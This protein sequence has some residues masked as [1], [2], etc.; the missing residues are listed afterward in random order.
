MTV[1]AATTERAQRAAV[2]AA[3]RAGLGATAVT[4]LP[5]DDQALALDPRLAT[6]ISVGVVSTVDSFDDGPRDGTDGLTSSDLT[7][8]LRVQIISRIRSADP[9]DSYDEHLDRCRVVVGL[10]HGADPEV[11]VQTV[12]GQTTRQG[13]HVLTLYTVQILCRGA[14]ASVS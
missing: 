12:Q 1:R 11:Q 9:A 4:D 10:L 6:V 3:L 7:L 2:I 14:F 8:T 5:P 13:S